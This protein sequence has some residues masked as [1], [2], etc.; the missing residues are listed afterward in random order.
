[1]SEAGNSNV[2][3]DAFL[4][5]AQLTRLVLD[6]QVE[7]QV[8]DDGWTPVPEMWSDRYHRAVEHVGQLVEVIT[9]DPLTESLAMHFTRLAEELRVEIATTIEGS[10]AQQKKE[11]RLAD[12]YR[13]AERCVEH[14]QRNHPYVEGVKIDY[15][16]AVDLLTEAHRFLFEKDNEAAGNKQL[17]RIP[18]AIRHCA[19]RT[20]AAVYRDKLLSLCAQYE[21]RLD[22]TEVSARLS[23]SNRCLAQNDGVGAA[24]QAKDAYK[25]AVRQ[26]KKLS[27]STQS[28]EPKVEG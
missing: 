9:T 11:L 17:S 28:P 27:A 13:R 1:M 19:G 2:F 22:L 14:A 21:G 15:Q 6:T 26:V 4:K 10:R 24:S 5:L 3:R 20:R 7:F 12:A 18:D 8:G 23:N 25:L 16:P